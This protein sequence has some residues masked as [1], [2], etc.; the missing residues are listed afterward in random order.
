M[1]VVRRCPYAGENDREGWLPNLSVDSNAAKS[2]VSSPSTT[3][4]SPESLRTPGLTVVTGLTP[5]TR[6]PQRRNNLSTVLWV[7]MISALRS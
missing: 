2:K 1:L 4:T 7:L 3:F 5:A 6:T